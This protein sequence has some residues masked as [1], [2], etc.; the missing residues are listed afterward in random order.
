VT[1]LFYWDKFTSNFK[2]MEAERRKQIREAQRGEKIH[3][4]KLTNPLS[5]G[6][7]NYYVSVI[8][9]DWYEDSPPLTFQLRRRDV[10]NMF[11]PET[12]E[13]C[14][15]KSPAIC[16]L[17]QSDDEDSILD[18]EKRE[19]LREHFDEWAEE[20]SL[21]IWEKDTNDEFNL[22]SNQLQR[23]GRLTGDLSPYHKA[24]SCYS[25][26][27]HGRTERIAFIRDFH[28]LVADM[29][30]WVSQ[31]TMK[32]HS[33][34]GK[35]IISLALRAKNTRGAHSRNR[36]PHSAPRP[37]VTQSSS[38]S[39][40]DDGDSDS[41]GDSDPP[42]PGARA[43]HLHPLTSSKRNKPRYLNRRVSHCSRRVSEGRRAA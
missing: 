18:D 9:N 29:R 39:G 4:K 36:T 6:L 15:D 19:T 7:V 37:A 40:G 38:G 26:I 21:S 35:K 25:E 43:H 31:L 24:M 11:D 5:F 30:K 16:I 2:K 41:S 1:H 27:C 14:P 17:E 3:Y 20:K 22:A 32:H 42:G 10:K 33:S 12:G 28:K 23:L 34:K 8:D 13:C